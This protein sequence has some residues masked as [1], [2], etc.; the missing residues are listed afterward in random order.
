MNKL[1]SLAFIL[2]LTTPIFTLDTH[3]DDQNIGNCGRPVIIGQKNSDYH[4]VI[5]GKSVNTKIYVLR[6]AYTAGPTNAI[7]ISPGRDR[8][9]GTRDDAER[10]V[11]DMLDEVWGNVAL[12]RASNNPSSAPMGILNAGPDN[13]LFSSDDS[14]KLLTYARRLPLQE[15]M[16]NGDLVIYRDRMND[17]RVCDH[18]LLSGPGFCS[19]T[20]SWTVPVCNQLGCMS[21][22]MDVARTTV[23]KQNINGTDEPVVLW[24]YNDGSFAAILLNSGLAVPLGRFPGISRGDTPYFIGTKGNMLYTDYEE[25]FTGE[26]I[27]KTVNL[28]FNSPLFLASENT[29]SMGVLGRSTV[30]GNG[31]SSINSKLPPYI[32]RNENGDLVFRDDFLNASKFITNSNGNYFY[33][34][35]MSLSLVV[36]TNYSLTSPNSALAVADC[37]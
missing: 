35:G 36:G 1:F 24:S 8:K 7:E 18:T 4:P 22:I 3:A 9:F 10:V 32:F 30:F 37:N 16:I 15:S 27:L 11:P 13:L 29:Q 26:R 34:T 28:N 23:V 31:P 17:I 20:A 19:D 25:E 12:T 2:S 21:N 33:P 6:Q 14:F 5:F